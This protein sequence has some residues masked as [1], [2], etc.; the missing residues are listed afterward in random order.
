ML[1]K[2]LQRLLAPRHP[3]RTVTF[4]ELSEIYLAG[5]LRTLAVGMV[6]IFLPLYL[7]R[8]GF[9][10]TLILLY[11]SLFYSFGIAADYLVSLLVSRVGPKHVMRMSFLLQ[12]VFSIL[13][14]NIGRLPAPVFV[15]ALVGCVASTMY[16]IPYN[17]DFSKVKH[18]EHGG[19]E[20]GFL[21]VMERSASVVGPL[22]GG[23]VATFVA[24]A[25]TFVFAAIAMFIA[26]IILMFT[27]EPMKVHQKLRF[28][29]VNVKKDWRTYASFAALCGENATSI[30]VWPIFMTFVVFTGDIYLKL[31]AVSSASVLITI[32]IAVPLGKV[33]DN[34]KGGQILRYSTVLNSLIHVL[35]LG[36]NNLF[37]CILVATIN[38]PNTLVYR[39]AF[40][41]GFYDTA[42]DYPGYRVAFFATCE[43]IA[44]CVRASTF[45]L[46]TILSL[47]YSA[48]AVCGAAF[49]LAAFYSILIRFE[50][51]PALHKKHLLQ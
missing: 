49:M 5:F 9:S 21:Q 20:L 2:L 35:R 43:M 41:K 23:A 51:F 30:I 12:T 47:H 32:L 26:A 40:I 27:P 42:D 18:K 38:E 7:Y 13:V 44:D 19:K 25:A 6:G 8:S 33:L 34:K 28:D 29:K 39:L 14:V 45:F 36:V 50:R 1:R 22:L 4:S 16:F 17:I 11:Y 31:G 48:R 46:L 37:G 24:P 3:W 10:F 15:L